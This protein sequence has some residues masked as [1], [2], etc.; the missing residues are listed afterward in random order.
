[1]QNIASQLYIAILFNVIPLFLVNV[2]DSTVMVEDAI[3]NDACDVSASVE[4]EC[5]V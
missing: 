1:M 4:G 3:V 5:L 2:V